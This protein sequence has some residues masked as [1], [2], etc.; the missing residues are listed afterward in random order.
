MDV[1]ARMMSSASVNFTELKKRQSTWPFFSE[2][3]AFMATIAYLKRIVSAVNI[4]RKRERFNRFSRRN[5][6]SQT[7]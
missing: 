2:W 1:V 4:K 3:D 6:F 7:I 5:A